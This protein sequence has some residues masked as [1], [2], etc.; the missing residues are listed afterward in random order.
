MFFSFNINKHNV[1]QSLHVHFNLYRKITP[2][3]K[4]FVDRNKFA[5]DLLIVILGFFSL[6][7]Q[8]V[9]EKDLCSI[10]REDLFVLINKI[11]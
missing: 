6:H 2:G 11:P 9:N 8:V 1:A 10:S 5:S 7:I 4:T 3:K